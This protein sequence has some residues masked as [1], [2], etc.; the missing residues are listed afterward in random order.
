VPPVVQACPKIFDTTGVYVP[1]IEFQNT[2][3]AYGQI[4]MDLHDRVHL[5]SAQPGAPLGNLATRSGLVRLRNDVALGYAFGGDAYDILARV[6]YTGLYKNGSFFNFVNVPP[7]VWTA[8]PYPPSFSEA[9]TISVNNGQTKSLKAGSYYD[10][11]VVYQG[12]TLILNGQ[13]LSPGSPQEFFFNNLQ[14]EPG[15]KVIVNHAE[16]AV[17]VVMRDSFV[18]KGELVNGTGRANAHVFGYFGTSLVSMESLLGFKGTVVT[19][20]ASLVLNSRA[21]E[22]AFYGKFLEVH[23]DAQLTYS[24]CRGF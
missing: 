15:G 14:V 12:G 7:I 3:V 9:G 8:P 24:P 4:G 13:A 6:S 11:I 21:Y 18:W 19:P 10:R 5:N 23:Q 2:P 20:N 22:G 17:R 1:Q 16:G